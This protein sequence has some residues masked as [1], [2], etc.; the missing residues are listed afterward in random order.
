MSH[1]DSDHQPPESGPPSRPSWTW[2]AFCT[3]LV[4]AGVLLAFEHRVHLL[5]AWPLIFLLVCFGSH[6]LMHR[7]H[8]KGGRHEH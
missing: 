1:E 4:V 2:L 5:G 8:G 7:G 3:F 6:F